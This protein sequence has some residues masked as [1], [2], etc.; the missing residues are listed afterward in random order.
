[1]LEIT[2]PPRE[3][4]LEEEGLFIQLQGGFLQLEYSLI[5]I[6]K[7]ESKWHK[8]FLNEDE[9]KTSE[10]MIDYIR[11]MT[12]N[13]GVNPDLY[14]QLPLWVFEKVAEYIK[15]PM[16]ASTITKKSGGQQGSIGKEMVTSELI[17]YWMIAAGVPIECE[18]WH[19]S[20]LITLIRIVEVKN[21]DPKKNKLDQRAAA[22]ER[23]RI[24]KMNKAKYHKP[25]K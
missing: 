13:R 9:E 11:C 12:V 4:F 2:I 14:N 17:Y 24:N 21:Q 3:V 25:K 20:R 7:W 19:L 15:D 1:M 23:A 16:T 10:E 6:S 5:S 8:P 18:K 22:A